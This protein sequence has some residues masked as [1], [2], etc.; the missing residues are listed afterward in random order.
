MS[1]LES[2]SNAL[3]PGSKVDIADVP[4]GGGIVLANG[5]PGVTP[6]V[7]LP[8]MSIMEKRKCMLHSA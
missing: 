3:T 5:P 2:L 4:V 8:T 1:F 7:V 6:P